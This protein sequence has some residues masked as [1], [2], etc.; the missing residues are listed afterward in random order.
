MVHQLKL[1]IH[2]L[3]VDFHKVQMDHLSA[4]SNQ[5]NCLRCVFDNEINDSLTSHLN[6]ELP[7]TTV[8]PKNH[9][10]ATFLEYRNQIMHRILYLIMLEPGRD[11]LPDDPAILDDPK[12]IKINGQVQFHDDGS[13]LFSNYVHRRELRP[14][15]R[16]TFNK[17]L[18]ISEQIHKLLQAK[19]H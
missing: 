2:I 4:Q 12:Y 18:D 17:V 3:N 16:F 10:Y 5:K 15:C 6:R 13:P 19:I 1:T 9:W 14:Y 11:Y 8:V 7:R